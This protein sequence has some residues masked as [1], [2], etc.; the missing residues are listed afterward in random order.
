MTALPSASIFWIPAPAT[1]RQRVEAAIE[2]LIALLDVIDGDE[3][4]EDNGDGEPWLGGF[5]GDCR[6]LEADPSD[7]EPSLGAPER[8][9]FARE[10]TIDG[11]LQP[12]SGWLL[13]HAVASQEHWADGS[14]AAYDLEEENAH[15]GE[16]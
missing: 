9:P 4:L 7:D 6:D 8:H 10:F 3:N 11:V 1:P 13:R 14:H 15:R 12:R 2:R 5:C 16:A